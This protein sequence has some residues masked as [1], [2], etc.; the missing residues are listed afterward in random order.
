VAGPRNNGTD[1]PPRAGYLLAI[2]VSALGHVGLLAFVIFVAPRWLHSEDKPIPAYTVKIVDS[3]PAGD[4]GSHLPPLARKKAEQP[5]PQEEAKVEELRAPEAIPLPRPEEDKNA[6]A[7]NTRTLGPTPTP[8]PTPEIT[9]EPTP[10]PTRKP[11]PE[12]TKAPAVHKVKPTPVPKHE[13]KK[14]ATPAPKERSKAKP[15]PVMMAKAEATPSTRMQ[16]ERLKRQLLAEELKRQ[17][18]SREEEEDSDEED[19]GEP[20]AAANGP[21]GSGPVVGALPLNGKGYGVGS[22]TGSV[23]MLQD[24]A[25]LLYYQTVQDRIKK[26]WNF[27]GGTS[28][29][30]ATVDFSIGADGALTG[31]KVATGSNDSAFDESVIRAIRRAAPFPPPP[32]KYRSE[33]TQ[34]IEARFSLGD[35]KS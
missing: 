22:G 9:P 7:L 29:L 18:K 19:E 5:R 21:R 6:I 25:F 12:P 30:T 26:A 31:V 10:E 35:L 32:D 4:L 28:D 2:F 8:T 17:A 15:T 24:P 3:L 33:F 34:G 20:A 11:T 13:A 1:G 14:H 16:M 23:G 27:T